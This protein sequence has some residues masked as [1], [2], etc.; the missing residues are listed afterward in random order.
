MRLMKVLRAKW[1]L[2]QSQLQALKAIAEGISNQSELLNRK[3]N[4]LFVA[5]DNRSDLINRK[6]NSLITQVNAA[7]GPNSDAKLS[8]DQPQS[9][10]ERIEAALKTLSE[11]AGEELTAA[12]IFDRVLDLVGRQHRGLF[13]GDRLL[14]LDKT[15]AFRDDPAFQRAIAAASSS[16]GANQYASP[17]GIAWRFNTLIWAAGQALTVPGDFV[18]CGVYEGDMAWVVTEMIDLAASGRR[19]HLFDTFAG[20]SPKYSSPDDINDQPGFFEFV[21]RDYKRPEIYEHVLRRFATKPYVVVRKGVVPDSLVDAPEV[22]A[23]LHI[24]MNSPGPER[25]ALEV[26][27][28]RLSP[29]AVIVFDDYG[30]VPFKK[31]KEAADE[32]INA[33]GHAIVELPTGQGL[34]VK[35]IR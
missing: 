25:A 12:R 28:D 32:F 22:I 24:D 31:Q 27:Y 35:P 19:F 17:D 8:A 1:A 2:D 20:F 15:A 13:W 18:E 7:S 16:T 3:F 10:E 9:D 21:D 5:H 26:L 4:Q 30:W 29:G 23:Y 33:R 11:F 6:F 14:T 34:A